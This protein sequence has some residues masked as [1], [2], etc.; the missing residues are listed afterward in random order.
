MYKRPGFRSYFK[1]FSIVSYTVKDADTGVIYEEVGA[2]RRRIAWALMFI[3]AYAAMACFLISELP[4]AEDFLA[5]AY[6]AGAVLA[7]AA[8]YILSVRIAYMAAVFKVIGEVEVN[9]YL[10]VKF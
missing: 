2:K 10:D 9:K 6:V 3:L 4:G 5:A 1:Q 8:Y 7:A